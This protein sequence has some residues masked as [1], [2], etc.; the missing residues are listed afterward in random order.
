M[1][2]PDRRRHCEAWQFTSV[3]QQP[4]TCGSSSTVD[5]QFRGKSDYI[6]AQRRGARRR[7]M[8]TFGV[9]LVLFL[10][11][12]IVFVAARLPQPD[13]TIAIVAAAVIAGWFALL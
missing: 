11:G 12:R 10:L 8:S 4:A 13:Q 1:L 2:G 9:L 6:A 3:E 7:A 5:D